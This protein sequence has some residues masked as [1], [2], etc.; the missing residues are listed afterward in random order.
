MLS[1]LKAFFKLI[2]W[3][4]LL[5]L[6]FTQTMLN[7]LVIGHMFKLIH[8]ELPLNSFDFILLVLS[9]VFMAAFGYIYNDVKDEE[10]DKIN[11]AEKRII[12]TKISKG[13]G[14]AAGRVFLVSA[15]GI[16]VYL[17]IKL[18]MIQLIF[19]HLLIA[20]GLWYYSAQLKKTVL[21][22]NVVI[23]LFTGLS[24]F[25]VWLYHL[26]VLKNN[27][28][29][30]VD[31]RKITVFVTYT[32][33]AYSVFAFLVN[34]IREIVKDVEDNVGDEKTGMKTFI[35]RYGLNKTKTLIYFILAITLALLSFTIYYAYSYNW[36]QLAIYLAVAVGIPMI[37]LFMNLK[38]AKN[39]K[40]FKD[41]SLLTK[42]IMIAGILS[43]QLFYINYGT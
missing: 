25:I 33:L 4:N 22:G 27:P 5:I 16:S 13:N 12:G 43:M 37:Y 24:V 8:L 42:I 2:R 10:V 11:K 28:V 26:V 39:K 19:L 38:S 14:L 1:Q 20:A 3:P 31:A 23:S 36:L 7:Y 32:V 29:M 40:D 6:V 9:T 34:M 41:L 21:I 18:E 15:I 17:G 30:M 35:I